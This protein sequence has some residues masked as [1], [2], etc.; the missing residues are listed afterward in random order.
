MSEARPLPH[1]WY[2][3]SV[4]LPPPDGPLRG[5]RSADVVVLGAGLTGLA[6]ALELA[7]R[8]RSVVVLEAERIGAG[9]SGRNGGQLIFG[10]GC[11]MG[12]LERALGTDAARALFAWSLEGMDILH[13]R[14]RRYRI[15]CD[16]QPGH[17][18]VPIRPRQ[19]R[20]LRAERDTL[21][22]RYGYRLE[23]WSREQLA[24]VLDSPRY[25][26]ALFD[27]RSGHLHPLKYLLGLARACRSLGVQIL[28]GSRVRA[29]ERGARV[30]FRTDA[31]S[32][33]AAFGVLAGNAYLGRLVPELDA[34]LMPVGSYVAVTEPLGHARATGLI[35]NRMAVADVNW[36]LDYFRLTADDRL[37]F[38]GRASYSTLPPPG[39]AAVMRRRIARV[40]PRIGPFRLEHLWGGRLG[41]TLNRAPHWGRLDGNLYFAQG[42]SGHGLN[43]SQLAGR[44]LA[45]AI[46]AQSTRLDPFARLQHKPFPGGRWLRTPLLVAAM[47]WYKLRDALW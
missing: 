29:V 21:A 27:P 44:I 33:D 36:A 34:R 19:E 3:A 22:E 46:L 4:D 11:E 2:A 13:D 17:A 47:G 16:W 20:A 37:L 18:H 39:L 25:R 35:R 5:A 7:E 28:E 15:D 26:G 1:P 8:G 42:F 45:E 41:I 14:C 40:F 38:G 24:A 9:A 10:Y 31:G 30:V 43:T 6:A 12:T 23:W 32:V